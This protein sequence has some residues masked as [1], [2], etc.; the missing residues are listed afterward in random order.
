MEQYALHDWAVLR[1]DLDTVAILLKA[2]SNPNIISS[3][4]FTP[5]WSAADFGLDEIFL[6]LRNYDGK[7][8]TDNSLTGFFGQRSKDF[9]DSLYRRKTL[10]NNQF[11][12]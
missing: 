1:G 2:G 9:L 7:I 10:I 3:D 5:L 11:Q 12:P 6:L 8:N 4:G